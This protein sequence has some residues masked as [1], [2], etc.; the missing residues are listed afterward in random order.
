M[1]R[2]SAGWCLP[3][4]DSFAPETVAALQPPRSVGMAGELSDIRHF[5]RRK[6][7]AAFG[8]EP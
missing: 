4:A 5:V 2:G 6:A 7:A 3:R 8:R 1:P